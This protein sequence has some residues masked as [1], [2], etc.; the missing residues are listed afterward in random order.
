MSPTVLFANQA[1]T[2][3]VFQARQKITYLREGPAEGVCAKAVVT[4]HRCD[5]AGLGAGTLW[6]VFHPVVHL[7]TLDGPEARVTVRKLRLRH[8][9]PLHRRAV[10]QG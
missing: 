4:V 6:R 3:H 1:R 2:L 7:D 9:P 5:V 8:Q 10:A